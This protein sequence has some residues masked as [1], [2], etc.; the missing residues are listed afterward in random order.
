VWIIRFSL[1]G[2]RKL[3]VIP[4][5]CIVLFALF[6]KILPFPELEAFQ[7]RSYGTVICDRNGNVLRVLPADDGVKREWASLNESPPGAIKIFI[8]AEDRR[9]Y[10]HAG[11][12]IFSVAGSFLRNRKAGRT[13]SGASTITM[14]LARL[15]RS[16]GGGFS[17]KAREAWDAL[18]IEAKL[19]KKEI[20]ELWLNN[21][22]FGSNIEGLPAITRSRFGRFVNQLDETRSALLA[23]I[24]RRPGLYDPAVN[25]D[26][27]VL[28]ALVLSERCGLGLNE[29]EL[30]EA[31]DETSGAFFSPM[32][33]RTPFLAPHFTERLAGDFRISQ[34]PVH[35]TK[36]KLTTTLDLS[37]Q[38]FAEEQLSLELSRVS[39]NR[40]SNGAILAI[41]NETGA[42]R[43]YVGSASWFDETISGIIVGIRFRG[44]PG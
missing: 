2:K 24:P 16:H 18:R 33:P 8:R 14:Q 21:I 44:Q 20:L 41:E 19:S 22:P 15:I 26:A 38:R 36:G 32:D 11:V 31:A 10:F 5:C 23:V 4:L 7:D 30:R 35:G 6:L 28:A 1:G 34:S 17:G 29:R 43:V 12:D 37:L 42:V 39:R 9:F 25:P 27:A 13:V 40:V 3:V